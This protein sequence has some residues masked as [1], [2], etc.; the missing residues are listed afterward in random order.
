MESH[1]PKL[2]LSPLPGSEEEEKLLVAFM[3]PS[4]FLG[5]PMWPEAMVAN[6][7]PSSLPTTDSSYA[8]SLDPVSQ[9]GRLCSLAST[10]STAKLR[11]SDT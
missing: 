1:I 8:C 2:L 11:H 4:H 5:A 7:L 3:L 6:S 10:C 9:R